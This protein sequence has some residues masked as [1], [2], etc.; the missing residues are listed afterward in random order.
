[1][2]SIETLL[3]HDSVEASIAPHF[4][5]ILR[6]YVANRGLGVA[7]PLGDGSTLAA[8]APNM[9]HRLYDR[10][11]AEAEEASADRCF[12]L[13]LGEFG[14]RMAEGH[15]LVALMRSAPSAYAALRKVIRYHG[16]VSQRFRF[17]VETISS[18]V[19]VRL[20]PGGAPLPPG[21]VDHLFSLLVTLL[22]SSS[23]G[24][25]HIRG[26]DLSHPAPEGPEALE[27]HQRIFTVA[28][29]FDAQEDSL[30]FD[31]ADLSAPQPMADG[32]LHD[33]L[34]RL[35]ERRLATRDSAAGRL[36]EKIRS[37]LLRGELPRSRS[38]ANDLDMSEKQLRRALQQE[39]TGFKR[40]LDEVRQVLAKEELDSERMSLVDIAFLLGYAEQSAFNHAFRRWTGLSPGE[41]RRA[42]ASRKN[43]GI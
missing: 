35:A 19:R 13:R 43:T 32:V 11:F 10:L 9:T 23:G 24:S 39:G 25:A 5:A 18:Q 30:L 34:E 31:E 17:R 1:M 26:V 20:L 41:Y 7:S 21:Q 22:A 29:R 6:S 12:G 38:L 28:P 40:L 3:P 2:S 14:A 33:T 36:A 42:A 16:L 27:E 4:F 37:C 8:P 15:L